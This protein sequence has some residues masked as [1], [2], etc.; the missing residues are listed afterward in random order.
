[1]YVLGSLLPYRLVRLFS[2]GPSRARWFW[3]EV[4]SRFLGYAP[5]GDPPGLQVGGIPGC[6]G[7]LNSRHGRPSGYFQWK[8]RRS[9]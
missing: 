5:V 1:M 9:F 8:P 2:V 4:V 3:V 6:G 7:K